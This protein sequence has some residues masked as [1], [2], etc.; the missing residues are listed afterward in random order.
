M[1]QHIT[2]VVNTL[3]NMAAENNEH[4]YISDV[5]ERAGVTKDELW[6]WHREGLIRLGGADM[7]QTMDRE[8]LAA[9]QLAESGKRSNF[10]TV[11]P[12]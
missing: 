12:R 2:T 7:P 5:I 1:T 3:A 9:S 6:A 4:L 11:R 10:Y 8:K